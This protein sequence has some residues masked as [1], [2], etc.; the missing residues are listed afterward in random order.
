MLSEIVKYDLPFNYIKLQEKQIEEMTFD[1]HKM[2][3]EKYINPDKMIYLIAGDKETQFEQLKKLRLGEPI[4][5]D[6]NAN[7]IKE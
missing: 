1:E 4:L 2:L 7:E 6:K 3:A 5:L